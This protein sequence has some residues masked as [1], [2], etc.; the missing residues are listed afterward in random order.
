MS[1]AEG[2]AAME[3]GDKIVEYVTEFVLSLWGRCLSYL[4]SSFEEQEDHLK[5]KCMIMHMC[6]KM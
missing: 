4:T 6:M 5:A 1:A 2:R 3:T